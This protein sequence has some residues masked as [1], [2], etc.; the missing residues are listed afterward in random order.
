MIFGRAS[1]CTLLGL[2]LTAAFALI[3]CSTEL[4]QAMQNKYYASNDRFSIDFENKKLEIRKSS[5]DI[6]INKYDIEQSFKAYCSHLSEFNCI[7]GENYQ[8]FLS[9]DKIG[10]CII[11]IDGKKKSLSL[12]GY[13]CYLGEAFL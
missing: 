7:D 12:S 5:A 10:N 9:R 8:I 1:V 13:I 11:F 2:A 4:D 3:S 6:A